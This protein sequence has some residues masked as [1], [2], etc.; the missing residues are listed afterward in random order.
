MNFFLINAGSSNTIRLVGGSVP[1]EGCVEVL[2]N[3]MWL[4][5][6]NYILDIDEADVVCRQLGYTHAIYAARKQCCSELDRCLGS[7]FHCNQR[8]LEECLRPPFLSITWC[9][10]C[11]ASIAVVCSKNGEC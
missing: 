9:P 2:H 8:Y 11:Q 6:S 10:S 7:I 1:N 4:R 3:R 5:V